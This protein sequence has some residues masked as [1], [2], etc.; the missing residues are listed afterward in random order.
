MVGRNSD[1]DG[2]VIV[3]SNYFLKF[4]WMGSTR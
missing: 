2:G 3:L 4:G 1:G